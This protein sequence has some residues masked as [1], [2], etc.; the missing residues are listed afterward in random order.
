[1]AARPDNGDQSIHEFEPRSRKEP[2]EK[3]EIKPQLKREA[4]KAFLGNGAARLLGDYDV[5][6]GP[7]R[8]RVGV[9]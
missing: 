4:I 8:F 5:W 6:S 9:S 7:A 3:Q 2:G 1:V